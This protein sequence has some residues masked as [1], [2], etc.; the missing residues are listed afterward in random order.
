MNRIALAFRLI[1]AAFLTFAILPARAILPESGWYWNPAESGRGFN[2]EIQDNALFLAAFVYRPDGSAAWYTGGGTMGSDR[3]WTAELYETVGG[4]CIG[5][6]YR[7]PTL[8]YMGNVS[9]TFT[10]ERSA[11][12]SM[13]GN[14]VSVVRMDWSN[15]GVASRDALL[16]EWST[17]EGDPAFPVYFADRITLYSPQASSAGPYAGGNVTG[18]ASR[19]AVGTYTASTATHAI[20]VDS[21]A[22][23]YTLYVFTMRTLNRVEGLSWTYL[24]TSSPSGSGMY[25]LAHRTKSYA[26]VRGLN[27]P[28][29]TKAAM[30]EPDRDAI[31]AARAARSTVKSGEPLA[32]EGLTIESVREMD[33]GLRESFESMRQ[34]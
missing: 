7:A 8:L 23:Y 6:G 1:L 21:S 15:S 11:V 16:G 19:L 30:E 14:S 2:L 34:D 12:I 25:F 31:D 28:G 29:V 10:N 17:T 4:Q 27:A 33:R 3:T 18:S 9:I 20:L 24:K 5:C 32:M 13:L 26:R 22:S